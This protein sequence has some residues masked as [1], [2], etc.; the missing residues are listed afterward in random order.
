MSFLIEA[1]RDGKSVAGYG[2][3]A[4]GNTLMN[5]AGCR[6]DLTSVSPTRRA[7]SSSITYDDD[8]AAL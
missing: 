3:A 5:Y 6:P 1:N 7:D 2:A 8:E 4:K